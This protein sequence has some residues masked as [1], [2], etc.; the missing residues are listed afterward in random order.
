MPQVR[1]VYM[2]VTKDALSLQTAIADSAAELARITGVPEN[3]ILT[4]ASRAKRGGCKHETYIRVEFYEE[5]AE[6]G[7]TNERENEPLFKEPDPLKD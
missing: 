2:Q 6:H 5:G 3:T 1:K 4:S 7:E